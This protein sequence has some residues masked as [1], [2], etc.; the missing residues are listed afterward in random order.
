M[1]C[2]DRKEGRD[3]KLQALSLE[4]VR[5][6]MK[7]AAR[8]I[9]KAVRREGRQL[10]EGPVLSRLAAWFLLQEPEVQ[11]RI[12]LEG[13]RIIED[14]KTAENP[15]PDLDKHA[16]EMRRQYR[17]AVVFFADDFDGAKVSITHVAI[18]RPERKPDAK[19]GGS[20]KRG[21]K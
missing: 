6:G 9:R 1:L 18:N 7:S 2:M 5:E 4:E 21:K 3:G 19:A 14:L 17:G 15:V 20:V 13:H 8:R 11:N 12:I 16:D 10:E